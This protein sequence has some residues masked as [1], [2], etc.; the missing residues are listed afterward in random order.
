MV[1]VAVVRGY[2]L[3]G[4]EGAKGVGGRAIIVLFLNFKGWGTQSPDFLFH[5]TVQYST[6][7]YFISL[8]FSIFLC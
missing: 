7:F 2:G 8:S 1:L 3:V 5:Y 4:A 6:I